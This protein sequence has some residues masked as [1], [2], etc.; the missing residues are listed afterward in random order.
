ML[1]QINAGTWRL[2]HL[3]RDEGSTPMNAVNHSQSSETTA[4]TAEATPYELIGGAEGVRRLVDRF[5]DL[6][7]TLPEAGRVRAMHGKDLTPMREKLS[8]FL[9]GWFGG[10]QLYFQRPDAKCMGSAHAAFAIGP[11]ERDEWMLCMRQALEE[12]ALPRKMVNLVD[13]AF[14]RTCDAFRNR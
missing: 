4:A 5:Y 10:P 14:F 8:D 12:S 7:D 13:I 3:R 9:S 11:R 6:M 1:R 2:A